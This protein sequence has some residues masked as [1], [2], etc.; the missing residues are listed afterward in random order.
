M[1][2]LLKIIGALVLLL[3]VVAGCG[4]GYLLFA[5]PKAPP[6]AAIKFDSSPEKLARGKYL[7]DHV[8]NCTSCHTRRDWTKFS[9]PIKEE[10]LGGGG[11][12]FGLGTGGTLYSK[13]ITP[14]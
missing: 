3:L 4:F 11:E 13:H 5:F 1:K 8:V 2:T 9:G 6:P 12:P 7:N 14:A 10:L